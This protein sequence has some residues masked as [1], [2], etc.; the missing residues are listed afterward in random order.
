[1]RKTVLIAL[2][3]C[4]A[5]VCGAA[6]EGIL[7]VLQTP[8]PEIID[9]V[10]L[11]TVADV[12]T[13]TP[14]L[15]KDGGYTYSY[16]IIT[17]DHYED[18]GKALN[19]EG[20]TLQ[21]KEWSETGVL[22]SVLKKRHA[23]VT[24]QYDCGGRTLNLIYSPRVNVMDYNPEDPYVIQPDT[25]SILPPVPQIVSLQSVTGLAVYDQKK[26]E[27]NDTRY[28]YREVVYD[29]YVRFSVQ[30]G[31]AGFTLVSAETLEDGTS[32]AVVTDGT[33]TLTVDYNLE[34]KEAAVIYPRG[35]MARE[36]ARYD[37]YIA[38]AAGE[39]ISLMEDVT[40]VIV[41]WEPVDEWNSTSYNRNWIPAK[42][43][44][45]KHYSGD[46]V[47]QI[48]ILIRYEY[49]RPEARP[50]DGLIRNRALL[51]GKKS[52]S[53]SFGAVNGTYSI[54]PG[55]SATLSG[56]DT[57]SCAIAFSLTDQQ[58][59]HIEDTVLE[60]SGTEYLDRFCFRLTPENRVKPQE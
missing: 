14:T 16:K 24:V 58:M 6:A 23:V 3:L 39:P 9:T 42:R 10:G 34:T 60:F 55:S 57:S 19:Q 13:P 11:H 45:S 25:V 22:T 53:Y 28:H 32:R 35:T 15:N 48:Y 17:Y 43:S 31:E 7:P 51:F 38:V 30:L 37:D 50:W 33:V 59:E 49:N 56:K 40:A 52:L 29:C 4:L 41:G 46:G 36:A 5:M 1:M 18:F 2:L 26:T 47:H 44:D 8:P 27:N 54:Y 21:S 12:D 20:F